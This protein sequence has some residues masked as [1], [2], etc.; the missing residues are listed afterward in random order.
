ML[1]ELLP[2]GARKTLYLIY[3]LLGVALGSVSQGYAAAEVIQPTWLN[4]AVSVFVYI[5]TAFGIVAA[6]NV[7]SKAPYAGDINPAG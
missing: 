2:D 5:G 1:N 7:V 3:A 6:G 4:I